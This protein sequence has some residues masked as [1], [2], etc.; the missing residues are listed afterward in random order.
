MDASEHVHPLPGAMPPS[1]SPPA[2][3]KGDKPRWPPSVGLIGLL[4]ALV[5]TF[6]LS[7]IVAT[8][9][10]VLGFDDPQDSA[11][12]EFVAIAAQS[13]AFVGAALLMTERLGRPSARDFGFR[14]FKSSALG[15]AALAMVSYFLLSAVYVSI[16]QPPQDD[17]PQ[18]LG[19]DQSTALAVVTGVFVIG[20][21]PVVEE[22]FFRGFLY[23]A[24]RTRIGVIG[25][26]VVSG[27]IFGAIHL[28]PEYLLPLAILGTALALLFEKTNSLWP[29]ILIHA[30]NNAIA[31]SVTV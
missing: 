13:A 10:V 8:I 12:F 5:A 6:V 31:F 21:A 26:A 7:G 14:P 28:K 19:A 11:S 17:L 24:L 9:Y 27:L 3:P 18:Q 2:S 15:W 22:F 20:I 29:C 16:A 4:V 23:Q 30:L 1:S 25:G